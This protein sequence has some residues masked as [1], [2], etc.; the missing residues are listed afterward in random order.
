MTWAVTVTDEQGVPIFR[1]NEQAHADRFNKARAKC[2]A[3]PSLSD[4]WWQGKT[5]I[6]FGPGLLVFEGGD[7]YGSRLKTSTP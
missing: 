7:I 2:V 5:R 4:K 6:D 3:N 1:G